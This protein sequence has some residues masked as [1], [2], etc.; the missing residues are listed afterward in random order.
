M[1]TIII[2]PTVFEASQV[3]KELYSDNNISLY[4][5]GIG[6]KSAETVKKILKKNISR[7]I[8][9]GFAGSLT[10]NQIGKVYNIETVTDK[11]DT[12]KL[13]SFRFLNNEKASLVTINKSVH[14]D[15]RRQ[16]L[17]SFAELVDMEGYHVAKVCRERKVD[18]NIIRI[19]S[20]SCDSNLENYFK[21]PSLNKQIPENLLLA[22]K[23]LAKMVKTIHNSIS[24]SFFIQPINSSS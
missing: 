24:F 5:S 18:L 10:G 14:T 22:Q 19:V 9:L 1:K 23:Q 17:I 4:I 2:I 12:I 8:L 11:K 3:S 16:N 20:D 15:M 7:V 21:N 13:D 6:K